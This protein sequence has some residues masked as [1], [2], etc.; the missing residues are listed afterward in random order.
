M[1][2]ARC[3]RSGMRTPTGGPLLE[4]DGPVGLAP[5]VGVGGSDGAQ[6]SPDL[7][8]A[9]GPSAAGSQ[10]FG[11]D[12]RLRSARDFVRV[13]QQGRSVSGTYVAV[14]YALRIAPAGPNG[15]Q[16]GDATRVG[17]TVGKRVGSAV[18]RNR[19]R[20]RLRE[21]MRR[22][23]RSLA[24]RWDVVVTAR[25]AAA[26]ATSADLARELDALLRRAKVLASSSKVAGI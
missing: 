10:R 16:H 7:A 20:R 24:P 11:R 3:L 13:R 15:L 18:T 5:S 14:T 19:V 2:S 17:F 4:W 22:S 25:P 12:H 8:Q 23:W 9:V 21:H 6:P 26:S 1:S